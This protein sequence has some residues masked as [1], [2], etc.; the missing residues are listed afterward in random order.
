MCIRDSFGIV[1]EKIYCTN[2]IEEHNLVDEK[3]VAENE[4]LR[5]Y[6]KLNKQNPMNSQSYVPNKH[7]PKEIDPFEDCRWGDLSGEE[8]WAAS[9]NCD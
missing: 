5:E 4:K 1:H 6:I 7:V 3:K 9:W 8:A 2:C